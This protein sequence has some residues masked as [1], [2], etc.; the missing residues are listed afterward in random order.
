MN[1]GAVEAAPT[2]SPPWRL[3]VFVLATAVGVLGLR[4]IH[5]FVSGF[6]PVGARPS[7]F[8]VIL[9]G[10]LL[11]GHAWTFRLV[12]PRGWAYVG[13]GREALQPRLLGAGALAGA[14]AIAIPAGVLLALG[15]L[16]VAPTDPGSASGAA[17]AAMALLLPASLWEELFVRGFA[18]AILRERWGSVKAL[19]AT[20]T[21]FGA[22]HV[23]NA[24]A[25]LLSVSVV[26][27]A[28]IFL[29][30]VLVRTGS[31]Y[32]AWAAHLSWNVV[33]VVGLHASVSGVELPAPGY[34]VID[35]GPDWAT[36]GPWGPEG[37]LFAAAGLV[38]A[39]WIIY[40]RPLRRTEPD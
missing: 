6:I 8:M 22:L 5:S 19:L 16:R 31:L 38:A 35:A 12:E 1:R 36:G 26:T 9:A 29:G 28:G 24:G 27:L 20:S 34:R 40:R 10:G 2:I 39:V 17:A 32:A 37:G 11:I 25:T 23:L 30:L 13:L 4:L 14:A 18:F 7:V 33:L 3:A 15:W 21:A